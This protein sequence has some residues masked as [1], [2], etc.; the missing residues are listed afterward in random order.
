MSEYGDTSHETSTEITIVSK[1]SPLKQD[2]TNFNLIFS[3]IQLEKGRLEVVDI[4]GYL[5]I[6]LLKNS[7]SV[8]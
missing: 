6:N 4:E 3:I 2:Q 1:D 5:E 8:T 7:V